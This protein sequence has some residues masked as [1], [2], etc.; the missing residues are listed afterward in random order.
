MYSWGNTSNGRLGLGVGL[1]LGLGFGSDA[2]LTPHKIKGLGRVRVSDI[3]CGW[4]HM[5]CLTDDGVVYSWGRGKDGQLG[6]GDVADVWEPKRIEFFVSSGVVVTALGCGYFHSA[7]VAGEEGV[8]Y[9][10]GFGGQGRLGH[11]NPTQN[12]LFPRAVEELTSARIVS[13]SCGESHTLALD[14]TI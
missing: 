3:A 13:V 11:G 9:T 10:W 1:G 5:M 2:V 4:S 14:C 8:L 12:E 7:A 6:H